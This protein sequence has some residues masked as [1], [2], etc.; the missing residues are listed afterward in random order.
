MP[1]AI[2][3]AAICARLSFCRF[4]APEEFDALLNPVR[5]ALISNRQPGGGRA[6]FALSRCPLASTRLSQTCIQGAGA[7]PASGLTLKAKDEG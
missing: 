3:N 5:A 7:M 2:V 4:S 6:R 1:E